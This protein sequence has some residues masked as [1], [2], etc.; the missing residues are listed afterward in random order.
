MKNLI[1]FTILF[2]FVG[3]VS[4]QNIPP[5]NNSNSDQS[6][7]F[8]GTIDFP[9]PRNDLVKFYC[10]TTSM[11]LEYC[12]MCGKIDGVVQC[13]WMDCTGDWCRIAPDK[14][15]QN[16]AN[17]EASI[18]PDSHSENPSGAIIDLA[19]TKV[20]I[21]ST[22]PL[23]ITVSIKNLGTK[24][25]T[26]S[27]ASMLS[28]I[29]GKKTSTQQSQIGKT[30]KNF[31]FPKQSLGGGGT[32]APGQSISKTFNLGKAPSSI[33]NYEKLLLLLENSDEGK[34]S[35]NLSISNL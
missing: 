18:V 16:P 35:N 23:Q 5:D 9:I 32:L 10:K 3:V 13:K 4:A 6:T 24:Q 33:S 29:A 34:I 7:P 11:G 8:V 14:S 21:F 2:L 30:S 31:S 15:Q 26:L 27:G 25:A 12:W 1:V 22:N 28:T 19:I 20:K 17:Y